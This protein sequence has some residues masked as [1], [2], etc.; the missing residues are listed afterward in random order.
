MKQK[1][2]ACRLGPYFILPMTLSCVGGGHLLAYFSK[3]VLF[4]SYD[5]DK[6]FSLTKSCTSSLLQRFDIQR[7][8]NGRRNAPHRAGPMAR[9]RRI[10][11]V[12]DA[13]LG[14][15]CREPVV[16]RPRAGDKQHF[17]LHPRFRDE[18]YRGRKAPPTTVEQQSC[19]YDWLWNSICYHASDGISDGDHTEILPDRANEDIL[20]HRRVESRRQLL[21][22]VVLNVQCGPGIECNYDGHQ[23]CNEYVHAPA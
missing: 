23:H 18:R 14:S 8:N 15:G 5:G 2:E 3:I 12:H 1:T 20:T 16:Q 10:G 9:R 22:L 13:P 21:E 19:N 4:V 17:T 7:T 6:S 11:H